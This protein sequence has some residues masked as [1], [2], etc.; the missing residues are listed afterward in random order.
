MFHFVSSNFLGSSRGRI[1]REVELH[2]RADQR[3]EIDV[4]YRDDL[5]DVAVRERQRG[6]TLRELPAVD[7]AP[8]RS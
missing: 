4:T 2:P 1:S 7:L 6:G 5:Y 3:Y 8:C